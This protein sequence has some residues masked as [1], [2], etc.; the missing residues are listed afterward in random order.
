M[1]R[2]H[3]AISLAVATGNQGNAIDGIESVARL[4]A[5][6]DHEAAA[7]RLVAN[8]YAKLGVDSRA[9]GLVALTAIACLHLPVAA[10]GQARRA[11]RE[12]APRAMA[13]TPASNA[14]ASPGRGA[15]VPTPTTGMAFIS[16]PAVWPPSPPLTTMVPV[17]LGWMRQRYV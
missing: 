9:K 17:M 5:L 16:A 10:D 4:T 1:A 12:A 2:L 11:V 3:E 13:A 15:A 6:T 7:A 8:V 14:T